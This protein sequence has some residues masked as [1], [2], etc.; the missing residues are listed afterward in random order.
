[1]TAL[2][3]SFCTFCVFGVTF[4]SLLFNI[5]R[6]LVDFRHSEHGDV[7]NYFVM[8]EFLIILRSIFVINESFISDV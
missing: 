4:T 2:S 6:H 8:N 3:R 7:R 1:M 5:H